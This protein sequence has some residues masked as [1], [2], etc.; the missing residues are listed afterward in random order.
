[1]DHLSP[2]FRTLKPKRALYFFLTECKFFNPWHSLSGCRQSEKL[3]RFSL[4]K[5]VINMKTSSLLTAFLVATAISC[6]HKKTTE[7]FTTASQAIGGY[8]PVSYFTED[9]AVK[10]R[11]E[12]SYKWKDATWLFSS[13]QNLDSFTTSPMKYSPQYGG[14]CAF[15]CSNERK[16]TT[17]PNAWTI[18]DGKLYLNHNAEVKEKWVKEQKQR[19][20]LADKNWPVIKDK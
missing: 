13:K 1:M 15:G 12:F 8:D 17:D 7:I 20:E 6:T 2:F 3:L 11:E 14:W 18:V 9:R 10:G 5:K 16:A 19:I 4:R